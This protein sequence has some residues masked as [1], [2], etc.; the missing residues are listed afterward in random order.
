MTEVTNDFTIADFLAYFFPGLVGLLGIYLILQLT[1]LAPVILIFHN[2]IAI[3][4][5]LITVSYVFGLI[6]SGISTPLVNL[7]FRNRKSAYSTVS[8]YEEN[9]K[10]ILDAVSEIFFNNKEIVWS[11]EIFYLCRALVWD[12]MPVSTDKSIRQD[13]LR[14]LR[15]NLIVVTHIWFLTGIL[16]TVKLVV[17]GAFLWAVILGVISLFLNFIITKSLINRMIRNA[18]REVEYILA[19]FLVCYRTNLFSK[20]HNSPT[21]I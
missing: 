6:L 21:K 7:Y 19:A 2:D 12:T 17:G 4:I 18:K 20:D 10:E 16:W 1:P 13:S 14:Q 11:S 8:P 3:L 9:K 5:I 15:K